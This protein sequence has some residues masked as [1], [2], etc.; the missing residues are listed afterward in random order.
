MSKQSKIVKG[1]NKPTFVQNPLVFQ[2]KVESQCTSGVK[3]APPTAPNQ[4]NLH[5]PKRSNL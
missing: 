4:A 3:F 5:H 1:L 2:N